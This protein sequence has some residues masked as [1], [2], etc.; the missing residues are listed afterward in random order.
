MQGIRRLIVVSA[1]FVICGTEAQAQRSPIETGGR[2]ERLGR[3]GIGIIG[4]AGLPADLRIRLEDAAA[5]GLKASGADV[6]S[7]VELSRARQS[8]SLG[9][10]SDTLCEQRLAQVTDTRYWLRGTCQLDTS[11]YRLHLELV[12]ARSGAVVVARDDT[13]DICTEADAAETINVAASALKAALGR[14]P[15]PQPTNVAATPPRSAT[16]GVAGQ[17]AITIDVNAN[18]HPTGREAGA[19]SHA[20]RAD[21]A[22]RAE[23]RPLWLRLLPWGAFVSAAAFGVAGTYYLALNNQGFE[24][25]GVP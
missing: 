14:A 8:A 10:C 21:R 24:C 12:D 1:A 13:C 2:P 6:V 22:D 4:P 20:D 25:G 19:S 3:I 9:T 18:A 15:Q 16:S 7:A 17:S 23:V 5:A 11:T